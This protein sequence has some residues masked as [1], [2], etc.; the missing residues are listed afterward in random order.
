MRVKIVVPVWGMD[1]INTFIR[2]SLASQ[3]SENN[4]PLISKKY[5]V[6]YVIY[7]LKS[8]KPYLE[9]LESIKLLKKLTSVRFEIINKFQTKNTYRI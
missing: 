1:Y 2:V 7:T 5:K 4:I 3:L 6:E 9:N 8:D